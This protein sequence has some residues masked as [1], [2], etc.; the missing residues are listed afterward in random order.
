MKLFTRL[1]VYKSSNVIFNPETEIATSYDWWVFVARING[2]LVFNNYNYSNSTCK[3]QSK[4]RSLLSKLGI[5]IDLFIESP[6]GLQ[7]LDSAISHYESMNEDLNVAINKKGSK[8]STNEK[9]LSDISYNM[10]KIEAVKSLME[11][12]KSVAV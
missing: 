3:H 1:N 10:E 11:Q 5:E 9:R 7:N 8:K 6:R 4:V 2:K 12:S